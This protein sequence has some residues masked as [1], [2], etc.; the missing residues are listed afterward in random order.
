MRL[1]CLI[2]H[3]H[4]IAV[5]YPGELIVTGDFSERWQCWFFL[6]MVFLYIVYTLLVGLADATNTEEKPTIWALISQAQEIAVVS[7]LTN[8]GLH[9]SDAR[10]PQ[11]AGSRGDPVRLLRL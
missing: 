8:R 6:M 3:L 2:H 9:L 4:V 1:L 5:G 7:W 11:G 10:L